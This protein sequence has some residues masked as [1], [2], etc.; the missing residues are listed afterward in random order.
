[1]KSIIRY[2]GAKWRIA[3]WIVSKI[4]EHRSYLEPFFGSGAVFFQKERSPIETINDLDGDVVNLFACIQKDPEKLAYLLYYTPYSREVYD[5]AFDKILDDPLE[6][7]VQFL[8]RLNM[9]YGYKTNGIKVGWK[10]D[11]QGRERAYAAEDWT[12][13]PGM[14]DSVAERLRGVQIEHMDAIQLIQRFNDP[15]VLIYCDPPYMLETRRGKQYQY[16][17]TDEQHVQLL[18]VLNEHRGPV[19]LSGYNSPLYDE[20]LKGWYREEVTNLTQSGQ[21]KKEILW[22]NFVSQMSIFD[23]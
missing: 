21:K 8:V 9:G 4:P 18:A 16:E 11:V 23:T 3:D 10:N 14:I 7:A 1:M 2:P 17:F 20:M 13:L 22:M 19:M 6:Q 12:R 15:K 5:T